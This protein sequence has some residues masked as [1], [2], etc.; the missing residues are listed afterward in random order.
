VEEVAVVVVASDQMQQSLVAEV[1]LL[2]SVEAAE[3]LPM[4][5]AVAVVGVEAVVAAVAAVV[6]LASDQRQ[7]S[8]AAAAEVAFLQSAEVVE[9][10]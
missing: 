10:A 8:L 5:V 4:R 9:S 1:A 2:P 3:S 6:V 7:Q